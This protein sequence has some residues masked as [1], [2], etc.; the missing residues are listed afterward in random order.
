MRAPFALNL[1]VKIARDGRARVG[2]VIGVS[3][4]PAA[5]LSAYTPLLVTVKTYR[6]RATCADLD[7]DGGRGLEQ[8]ETEMRA[9]KTGE[10]VRVV[11]TPTEHD[12][13]AN[14]VYAVA[15]QVGEATVTGDASFRIAGNR[16]P[17]KQKGK[18]SR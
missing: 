13:D 17:R 7:G 8:V 16:P 10:V 1:R 5:G 14:G 12:V 9:V 3:D 11:L 4:D 2:G 15:L 6:Y 18:R